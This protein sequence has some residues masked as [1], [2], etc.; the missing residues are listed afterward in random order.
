MQKSY[1]RSLPPNAGWARRDDAQRCITRCGEAFLRTF[2]AE[3][4]K[5]FE[6]ICLAL[7]TGKPNMKFWPLY[8]CDSSYCG[9]AIDQ[10][11]PGGQDPNVDMIITRC[12]N[13][14][15][16]GIIDPGPLPSGY[17]CVST[18]GEEQEH[19]GKPGL[20]RAF[21]D[22]A[23]FSSISSTA[24]ARAGIATSVTQNMLVTDT[25][26]PAA[27]STT[28]AIRTAETHPHSEG[29]SLST[30]ARAAIGIGSALGII[31][32][33]CLMIVVRRHRRRMSRRR[34][35]G[36]KELFGTTHGPTNPHG[37][38]P[39]PLIPPALSACNDI[40]PLSPPL[41]LRDR[42]L[43]ASVLRPGNRCPSPPLT[44]LS[45]PHSPIQKTEVSFPRSP[46]CSPSKE[47]L[48]PRQETVK[49]RDDTAQRTIT[50]SNAST[51]TASFGSTLT[52][53]S[54]PFGSFSRN[55]INKPRNRDRAGPITTSAHTKAPSPKRPPRPL[56]WPFDASTSASSLAI[57]AVPPVSPMVSPPASP[58]DLYPY[59]VF[60][61]PP[62]SPVSP[63]RDTQRHGVRGQ[64]C[65]DLF[66]LSGDEKREALGR[67]PIRKSESAGGSARAIT[68]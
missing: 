61:T 53:V 36:F 3:P 31:F 49:F 4:D 62:I 45:P 56:E 2:E 40:A 52:S 27:S 17:S 48:S 41:R 39:T 15:H 5:Y 30:G 55:G 34:R 10:Q 21:I 22:D 46:I 29:H 42:K 7:T 11:V 65:E 60:N 47:R 37:G 18:S 13:I 28:G 1:R 44:S 68:E 24:G 50:Q 19:P 32:L 63:I 26:R 57:Q 51:K 66:K 33:I 38:S 12:K 35:H 8:W 23:K 25:A 54:A 6:N 20:C 64:S 58:N 14:G 9:V 67:S 59:T 43:L 16:E